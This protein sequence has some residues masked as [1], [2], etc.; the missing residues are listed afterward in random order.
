VPSVVVQCWCSVVRGI[1]HGPRKERKEGHFTGFFLFYFFPKAPLPVREVTSTD[2][3]S[4][5]LPFF[6]AIGA[7]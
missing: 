7:T 4:F 5:L 2:L 6:R 3:P 1:M